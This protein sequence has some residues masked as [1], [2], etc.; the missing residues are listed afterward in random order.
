MKYDYF[1]SSRW[2]N[3]DQ[4]QELTEKLRARNK[5]VYSFL[6]GKAAGKYSG[7][8]AEEFM[9]K[10][11]KKDWQKDL[12]VKA[13][14]NED[15]DGLKNSKSFIL[16][17]PAGNSCH[18]EAGIAFALNKKC[19]LIGEA[20]KAESLYLIFKENYKDINSFLKVL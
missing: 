12:Y 17:L 14:F 3:K 6:E 7:Q 8:N 18:L 15:L 19:I 1:V 4:I 13:V 9:K 20:E 5:T 11:E 10:F 16:L 2:R